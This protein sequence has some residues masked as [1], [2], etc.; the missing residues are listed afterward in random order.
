M[1]AVGTVRRQAAPEDRPL[2]PG[3]PGRSPPPRGAPR[4]PTASRA[5]GG[6]VGRAA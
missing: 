3:R 5:S 2:H 4:R 1:R 6:T